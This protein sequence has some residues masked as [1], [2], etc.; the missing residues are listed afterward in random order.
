MQSNSSLSG[1]NGRLEVDRDGS[2]GR[3]TWRL[4]PMSSM[5]VLLVVHDFTNLLIQMYSIRLEI[6]IYVHLH[7]DFVKYCVQQLYF[8]CSYGNTKTYEFTTSCVHVM[9]SGKFKVWLWEHNRRPFEQKLHSQWET[10]FAALKKKAL[11]MSWISCLRGLEMIVVHGRK[12]S[13]TK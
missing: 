5:I 4:N 7:T 6:H 13:A 3:P 10:S 11:L 12:L 1:S 9:C 8:C 2:S